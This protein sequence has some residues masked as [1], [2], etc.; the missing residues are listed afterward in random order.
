[1]LDGP[2]PVPGFEEFRAE[3]V[4]RSI[5]ARFE[6]QVARYPERTAVEMDQEIWSYRRLNE[7][8]NRIARA[9]LERPYPKEEPVAL[10]FA[11]G[12]GAVVSILGVLKAG[13]AWV[14]L[15]PGDPPERLR[16]L[17]AQAGSSIVLTDARH[18]DTA[19]TVAS[20]TVEALEIERV[21][22]SSA[23]DNLD[24]PIAPNTTANV[25]FTSGSTGQPKG[26]VYTHATVLNNIM[27]NTNRLY[28]THKDR[29]SQVATYATLAGVSSTFRPLLNGAS[30]L[31][32]DT[33][34]RGVAGLATWMIRERI[35]VCQLVPT[36][37]R[38]MIQSLS[39]GDIFPAMR[40]VHLGG[41]PVY[42]QDVLDF[43]KHFPKSCVLLHNLGSTEA[44]TFRQF[45][46]AHDTRIEEERLPVGYPVPGR[47]VLLIDENGA[48]VGFGQAG[49]IVVRSRH[50]AQGY[51]RQP[52]LTQAAFRSDPSGDGTRRFN[53]GDLGLM[54][55]AGCLVHLGRKDAQVKVHGYRVELQE[56]EANL[57][58]IGGVD[59][60]A[61]VAYADPD[62]LIAYVVLSPA[63]RPSEEM[64]RQQ[65]EEKLPRHMMPGR[66]II[67]P[68]L[69]LTAS[70]KVDRKALSTVFPETAAGSAAPA[71]ETE[72]ALCEIWS[73]VL[74]R[75]VGTTDD[76]LQ[77]GG[78]SV[79]GAKILIRVERKFGVAVPMAIL[80][81]RPTVAAMAR[82]LSASQ[83]RS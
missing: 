80:F 38:V 6:S 81:D 30:L 49:E 15:L 10:L 78:D 77:L 52:E 37:F 39:D 9:V 70:G 40:I 63:E 12:I 34:S 17:L 61:V 23:A 51:W 50:L 64:I 13:R 4:E 67:V 8:A 71:E 46:V 47:E 75:P 32:F 41:E 25:I 55:P 42:R 5:P 11:P 82:W 43:R 36:L 22:E 79:S 2:V 62:A 20:K 28:L 83:I 59:Q 7:A 74:E 19:K 56:I 14:P 72:R 24:L 21:S 73:E 57:V 26:V 29:F 45:F 69:P 33:A 60:A 68:K 18:M 53:T 48:S 35:T 44:P 65:L 66:V 58:S 31:P 16:T 27:V 54:R 76:F 1:M 3:D